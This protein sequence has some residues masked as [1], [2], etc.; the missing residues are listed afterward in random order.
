MIKLLAFLFCFNCFGATYVASIS[1]DTN[2]ELTVT[3]L[4]FV[5]YTSGCTNKTSDA[6]KLRASQWGIQAL[7][8][9]VVTVYHCQKQKS[10]NGSN[11][12]IRDRN[13]GTLT[14]IHGNYVQQDE[15]KTCNVGMKDVLANDE[16]KMRNQSGQTQVW[17]YFDMSV[18]L[19]T[20]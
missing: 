18:V 20:P 10:G 9:G 1:C 8:D 15:V 4:Q 16:I 7:V 13:A 5:T 19:V 17:H 2:T 3:N 12:L 11:T 14:T 6:S